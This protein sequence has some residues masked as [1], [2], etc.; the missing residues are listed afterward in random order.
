MRAYS[1]GSKLCDTV[2]R[3]HL[4]EFR[5]E[6]HEDVQKCI[7]EGALSVSDSTN[8]TSGD[9]ATL[10]AHIAEFSNVKPINVVLAAG[11]DEIL[12]AA[13][14]TCGL[15]QQT[16]VLVASP[17]Y[18]HFL[19]YA[20]L[21][22]LEIET[23]DAIGGIESA[24]D[25]LNTKAQKT[26]YL[27]Y[28]GNP[29]NPIGGI[30]DQKQVQDM[31]TTYPACTFIVDEA[32]IE[33]CGLEHSAIKTCLQYPNVLVSRTFSKAFGLAGM[34]IGYGVGHIDMIT[35]V[36][37]ALSPKAVRPYEVRVATSVM[38]QVSYYMDLAQVTRKEVTRAIN[39][40]ENDGWQCQDGIGNFFCVYIGEKVAESVAFLLEKGVSVRNRDDQPGLTGCIRVTGG[41]REDMDAFIANLILFRNEHPVNVYVDGIFDL[42]HFGHIQFLKQAKALGGATARILVG[43]I[44]DEDAAWK[45]RPILNYR[46]RLEMLK[47]CTI[48]DDIVNSAPLVLTQSFLAQHAID[49]VVHGDDSL[50][51]DFFAVPIQMGIMR[52]VSYTSAISTTE[53]LKRV[54]VD[55]KCTI[56]K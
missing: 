29:N 44:S 19:H 15:R 9:Y 10:I 30:C 38:K 46:D 43:V 40:L 1:I 27:V 14:D 3:L 28:M 45:R 4:N 22:G 51:P 37:I 39:I 50:Q 21:K 5:F 53:I 12:R 25:Y 55:L 18:S 7:S 49:L 23:Y 41:T 32:Y 11:S 6:H 34:R 8:Y 56:T 26:P 20:K 47:H 36:L 24:H 33:F 2:R 13:V 52:Y 16:R 54:I 35:D 31:A 48:V 17:G 42:F